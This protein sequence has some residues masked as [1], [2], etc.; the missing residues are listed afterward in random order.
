MAPLWRLS[1]PAAKLD[2]S[3]ADRRVKASILSILKLSQGSFPFRYLGCWISPYRIPMCKFKPLV[4]KVDSR[5][6]QWKSLSLSMAGR[7][8]LANSVVMSMPAYTLNT[9][10][11]PDTILDGITRSVRKFIWSSNDK[12]KALYLINWRTVIEPKSEGGLGIRDLK[13]M[14]TSLL[15]KH[16]LELINRRDKTWVYLME[17]KYGKLCPWNI[18]DHTNISWTYRTM[19][20]VTKVITPYIAPL[21]IHMCDSILH[22]PWLFD[23][24]ICFKPTFIN[25]DYDLSGMQLRNITDEGKWDQAI[26]DNLFP[27]EVNELIREKKFSSEEIQEKWVWTSGTGGA[28]LT[29]AIY[30]TL[31]TKTGERAWMGWKKTLETTCGPKG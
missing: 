29:S 20:K 30:D 19:I 9:C 18:T 24:P 31:R 3:L 5:L 26:I 16:A 7:I 8:T 28:T 11:I 15:A 25:I 14:R 6:A 22:F 12:D 2:D 13:M 23:T 21:N 10:A 17:D 1:L 4:D 27:L